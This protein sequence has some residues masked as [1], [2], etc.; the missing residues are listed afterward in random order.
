MKIVSW[1]CNMNFREKIIS[2]TD[3]NSENYVDADIYVICECENPRDPKPKYK[4]YKKTVEDFA[5]DN[6]YWIGDYHY[7]GLGIFAKENVKLEKIEGLNE[8]F[9]NF[10]PLRVNDSF[11]LLCVWAMPKY[12]EMIHDYFDANHEKLFDENLIM[13]G[14]FNSNAV[15]NHKHRAKDK[16]GNAK[17]H[18]NL[19]VKLNSKGLYSL[20][21]KL[22]GEENG[23]ESKFTF[24]Q[25]KHLNVPFYL[26]YFYA[27]EEIIKK[28]EL[29][30][31]WRKADDNLPNK[32]EILDKGEWITLSDHLPLVFE[33]D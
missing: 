24:F 6:Y 2:I 15:F 12:I 3:E 13:C 33:F 5:G 28:T 16:N 8:D 25:A 10:I 7:K 17:D 9:K 31:F 32:F 4:N 18:T 23:K 20:Y 21:H 11:N 26:D 29:I 14:D 22:S 19:D 30:D 27:Y 1:N